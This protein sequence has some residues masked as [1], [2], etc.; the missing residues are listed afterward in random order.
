MLTIIHTKSTTKPLLFVCILVEIH[1]GLDLFDLF[2]NNTTFSRELVNVSAE[3]KGLKWGRF[4][5]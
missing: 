4:L 1:F 2:V 5:E 3:K